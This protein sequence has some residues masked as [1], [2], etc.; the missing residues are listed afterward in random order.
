M[1]KKLLPPFLWLVL[2]SS[3]FSAGARQEKQGPAEGTVKSLEATAASLRAPVTVVGTE[4]YRDGGTTAVL[5]KD[6]AGKHFLFCLEMVITDPAAGEI[7]P[8]SVFVGVRHPSEPPDELFRVKRKL[9]EGGGEESAL[10]KLLRQ[11]RDANARRQGE[12]DFSSVARVIDLVER[13]GALRREAAA[14]RAA[15]EAAVGGVAVRRFVEEL[16]GD[17]VN[18]RRDAVR[19]KIDEDFFVKTLVNG[20]ER[21]WSDEAREGYFRSVVSEISEQYG[22]L[23][24]EYKSDRAY[25]IRYHDDR[26]RPAREFRYACRTKKGMEDNPS[27]DVV[28]VRQGDRLAVKRLGIIIC[29]KQSP[30]CEEN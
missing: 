30:G 5:L 3:N 9:P 7:L 28:V 16:I 2:A 11:W 15:A 27:L 14:V 26:R 29:P 24:C 17:L 12:E 6:A 10:I 23:G 20:K 21:P 1:L 22:L 4:V 25:S 19:A 13:R 8:G 18:D